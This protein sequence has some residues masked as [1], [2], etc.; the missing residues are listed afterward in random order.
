[1]LYFGIFALLIAIGA[2][3]AQFEQGEIVLNFCD[4]DSTEYIDC[5][6]FGLT[7]DT[8]TMELETMTSDVASIDSVV[9]ELPEAGVYC[10]TDADDIST[11]EDDVYEVEVGCTDLTGYEDQNTQVSFTVTMTLSDSTT[12]TETG[13]AEDWV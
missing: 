2:C 7:P 5:A 11:G 13:V 4:T 6:E 9:F 8:I 3:T 1:M 12:V 10:S